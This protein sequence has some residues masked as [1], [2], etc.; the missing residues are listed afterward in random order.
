MLKQNSQAQKG[1]LP[2]LNLLYI[3]IW[4]WV[5]HCIVFQVKHLVDATE[6]RIKRKISVTIKKSWFM[7]YH[8]IISLKKI[9]RAKYLPILSRVC[10]YLPIYI[11]KLYKT[12]PLQ[13]LRFKKSKASIWLN[14]PYIPGQHRYFSTAQ[15][16]TKLDK[17]LLLSTTFLS[18]C[19]GACILSDF[20]LR[21]SFFRWACEARVEVKF[22]KQWKAILTQSLCFCISKN[23]NC[24]KHRQ[25]L[26]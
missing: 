13:W 5:Q 8:I 19:V 14:P 3:F 25:K 9:R 11:I 6:E 15:N 24:P 22:I 23:C 26:W 21:M 12:W 10:E 4:N 20:V 17:Q 1:K 2:D 16:S 18:L 7:K